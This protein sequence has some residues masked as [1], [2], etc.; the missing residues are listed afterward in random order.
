M[1][2]IF[3]DNLIILEELEHHI[4]SV[5]PASGSFSIR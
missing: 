4:K 5:T 1:S 3:Y 2:K